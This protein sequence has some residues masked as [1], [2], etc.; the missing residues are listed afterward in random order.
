MLLGSQLEVDKFVRDG[1]KLVA[2]TE[3]VGPPGYLEF[4]LVFRASNLFENFLFGG[5]RYSHVDVIVASFE[6]LDRCDGNDREW[7]M[8]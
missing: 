1:G 3:L 6:H 2:E 7:D 4:E 5:R 8:L